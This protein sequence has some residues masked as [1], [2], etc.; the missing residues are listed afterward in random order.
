MSGSHRYNVPGIVN[1]VIYRPGDGNNKR[2]VLRSKG[3]QEKEDCDDV[4]SWF[5]LF[6]VQYE[7]DLHAKCSKALSQYGTD[8]QRKMHLKDKMKGNAW[9]SNKQTAKENKE[10]FRETW[11]AMIDKLQSCIAINPTPSNTKKKSKRADRWQ[12]H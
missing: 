11:A 4:D 1:T 7:D 10:Y 2:I 3:K 8:K 12:S 5:Q 9:G 6:S